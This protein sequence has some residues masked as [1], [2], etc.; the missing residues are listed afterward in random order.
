MATFRS[1]RINPADVAGWAFV[2]ERP[3][4]PCIGSRAFFYPAV[5]ALHSAR[6]AFRDGSAGD[7][8]HDRATDSAPSPPRRRCPCWAGRVPLVLPQPRAS[9]CAPARSRSFA[10]PRRVARSRWRPGA[11]P[12]ACGCGSNGVTWD[13]SAERHKSPA[14]SYV[15]TR[16][17]RRFIE[18][19]RGHS[20]GL[21]A[22]DRAVAF[23]KGL[24]CV[25]TSRRSGRDAARSP[26]SS[27]NAG[28]QTS[29]H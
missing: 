4:R 14:N 15:T 12:A 11:S 20:G 8:F 6:S 13:I 22:S 26:E 27:V 28:I 18:R 29:L 19:N 9:D 16:A 17:G 23:S 25:L 1:P 10:R 7:R 24:Q 5:P 3:R 21:A 2:P